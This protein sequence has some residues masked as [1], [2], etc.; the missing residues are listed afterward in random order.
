[1]ALSGRL[2]ASQPSGSE[3]TALRKQLGDHEKKM[4]QYLRETAET[5][6]GTLLG[7]I[8]RSIIPVET[9]EPAVPAGT[10]NRDSV[11]R[12]MS[13]LSYKEHFFD[14]IDFTEPGLIRSP[15]LGGRLE[16]YFRQVVIQMPDSIIK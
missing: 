4:K 9:P 11:A 6:K 16:Q 13:Y 12:L 7:A 8:A 14:N 10:V 3:A 5:N 1:M 15:V 2:N